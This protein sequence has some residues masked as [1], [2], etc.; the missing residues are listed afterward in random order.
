MKA[1]PKVALLA[2]CCSALVLGQAL[3]QQSGGRA[4][5]GNAVQGSASAGGVTSAAN[6]GGA[7]GISNPEPGGG[8]PGAGDPRNSAGPAGTSTSRSGYLGGRE[9]EQPGGD[10]SV[11]VLVPGGAI[12]PSCH[13]ANPG[14]LTP[15]ARLS[16]P[17]IGRINQA[18]A[19]VGAVGRAPNTRSSRYLLASL[20]E[21]LSKRQPDLELAA[22]YLGMAATEAVT[23]E[24]A[25]RA[26]QIL[27]VPVTSAQAASMSTIAESQRLR[28]QAGR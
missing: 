21:E 1:L 20:Q 28:M 15:T 16:G 11:T 2:A 7:G 3:A 27:C 17:N 22:T 26:S 4:Q 12:E 13:D 5:A 18:R 8:Q 23:P 9:A 6:R 14:G 24:L 19:L 10:T 25:M